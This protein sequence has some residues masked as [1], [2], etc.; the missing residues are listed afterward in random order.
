MQPDVLP[1]LLIEFIFTFALAFVVLNVAT[2][3]KTAGNS[4]FGVEYH[5]PATSATE[6]CLPA[7]WTIRSG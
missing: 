6:C 2:V 7:S 3:K 5:L 4:Y 1:A